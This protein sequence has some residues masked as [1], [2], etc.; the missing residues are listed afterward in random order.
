MNWIEDNITVEIIRVGEVH[1]EIGNGGGDA[2][3]DGV[4]NV[5]NPSR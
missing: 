1:A 3:D 4:S 5:P 2:H